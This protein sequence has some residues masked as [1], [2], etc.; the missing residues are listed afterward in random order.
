[1]QV[2]AL[3]VLLA[4]DHA[5]N[6]IMIRIM[7]EAAG[8]RVDIVE[9]GRH[10]INAVLTKPYDV[11]LM[12]ISMPEMDGLEA[13]RRIR[14]LDGRVSQ[15]PI[16]ALT[17]HAMAGDREKCMAAGTS[18]YLSK[19]VHARGLIMALEQQSRSGYLASA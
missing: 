9:N 8:H 5:L 17:A 10:A 1:A 18:D 4:E 16:I 19:P 3:H 15:I 7:L 14:R 13:T 2:G 6:Q 11:V 12:D